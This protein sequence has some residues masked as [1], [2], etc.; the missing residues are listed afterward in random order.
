MGAKRCCKSLSRPGLVGGY[1]DLRVII[2]DRRLLAGPND[3][4]G[5]DKAYG[6]AR[7]E[8]P[9]SS[10]EWAAGPAA[11]LLAVL[12]VLGDLNFG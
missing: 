11:G 1:G 3:R 4:R 7:K 10:G 2:A 6:V 12:A 5:L 9:R 8:I